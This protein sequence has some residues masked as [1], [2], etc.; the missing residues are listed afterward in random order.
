MFFESSQANLLGKAPPWS[1]PPVY[2]SIS[3]LVLWIGPSHLLPGY[4]ATL[5]LATTAQGQARGEVSW[6]HEA[7]P[8]PAPGV[9]L[10]GRQGLLCVAG[11]PLRQAPGGGAQVPE[12]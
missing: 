7:P 1:Y 3:T 10:Q 6:T 9:D 5:P 2:L 11:A 8:A 12:T 4:T